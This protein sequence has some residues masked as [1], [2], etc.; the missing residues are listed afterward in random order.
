MV[1]NP[2]P[3][4]SILRLHL[5]LKKR[6]NM[7][8]A[9]LHWGECIIRLGQH[10]F[11]LTDETGLGSSKEVRVLTLSDVLFFIILPPS[12]CRLLPYL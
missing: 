6:S 11:Q 12:N 3:V 10:L 2:F 9:K 4:R 8:F 7:G 5:M 1:Y